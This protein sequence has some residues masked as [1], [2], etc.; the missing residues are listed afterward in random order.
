MF[1][2]FKELGVLSPKTGA[3]YREKVLSKGGTV[4][5]FVM[6]KDYLGRAPKTDAF[7]NYLGLTA[8]TP[9]KAKK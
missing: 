9:A 8:A 2:R 1:Q 7:L 5:A 3:Y 6:L 4:D